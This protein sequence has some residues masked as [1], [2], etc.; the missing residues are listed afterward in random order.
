MRNHCALDVIVNAHGVPGPATRPPSRYPADFLVF[1]ARK[2]RTLARGHLELDALE[3]DLT[4][5]C[6][7]T[8]TAASRT[9]QRFLAVDVAAATDALPVRFY[10]IDLQFGGCERRTFPSNFKR[11]R[12]QVCF[13][14]AQ[15]SDANLHAQCGAR[16][17]ANHFLL[18]ALD[19]RKD[20]RVFVHGVE[21]RRAL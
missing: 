20:Q 13:D 15:F 12:Q 8:R 5:F 2:A 18:D 9:R 10:V 4:A 6:Q 11:R 19:K 17:V 16:P 7:T 21:L 1:A 3:H 14:T